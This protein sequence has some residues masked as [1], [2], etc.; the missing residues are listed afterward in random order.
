MYSFREN[1]PELRN[2]PRTRVLELTTVFWDRLSDGAQYTA[3]RCTDVSEFG[4]RLELA[5][6]IPRG[7]HLYVMVENRGFAA[8]ATVRHC[9]MTGAIGVELREGSASPVEMLARR[10]ATPTSERPAVEPAQL[11]S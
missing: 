4:M 3:G 11:P 10:K 6:V 7:T 5:E 2:H 8:F 1:M 9:S